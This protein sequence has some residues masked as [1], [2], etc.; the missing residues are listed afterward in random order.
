MSR[1][2]LYWVLVAAVA[3]IAVGI[4]LV[5]VLKPWESQEYKDCMRVAQDEFARGPLKEELE[6]FCRSLR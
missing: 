3:V 1:R 2:T 5:L 4:A 6:D